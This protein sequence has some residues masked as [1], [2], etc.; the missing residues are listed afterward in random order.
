[1][2]RSI[3]SDYEWGANYLF[4]GWDR[5]SLSRLAVGLDLH[6]VNMLVADVPKSGMLRTTSA[7]LRFALMVIGALG[8][9]VGPVRASHGWATRP[10]GP[11]RLVHG[12]VGLRRSPLTGAFEQ[13]VAEEHG[14]VSGKTAGVARIP[15]DGELRAAVESRTRQLVARELGVDVD[16]LVPETSLTDDLAADSLDML[17]LALLLES[18]FTIGLP[19]RTLDRI[20]TFRDLVDAV[21]VSFDDRQRRERLMAR[22]YSVKARVVS[23][24]N[25]SVTLQRAGELTP[26]AMELIVM[27]R[28]LARLGRRGVGVSIRRDEGGGSE[29]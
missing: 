18:H 25:Q 26:Y 20:R 2:R 17:Q 19:Q 16:D 5:N 3:G 24:R 4:D 13:A 11:R 23:A 8:T 27:R 28:E 1:V 14:D 10:D 15:G 21:M 6:H 12:R 29:V 9:V 22:P 7:V